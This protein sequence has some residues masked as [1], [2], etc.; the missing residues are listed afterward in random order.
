VSSLG[1]TDAVVRCSKIGR[2]LAVDI[3][4]I[5]RPEAGPIELAELDRIRGEVEQR[6]A[7]VGLKPWMNI[8]FTL[9]RRWA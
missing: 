1:F 4:F 5:G 2:E 3:T 7:P 8:L 9:D 6:L